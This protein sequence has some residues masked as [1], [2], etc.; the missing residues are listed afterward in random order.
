MS[1]SKPIIRQQKWCHSDQKYG[2]KDEKCMPQNLKKATS[3]TI[4][5]ACSLE[6]SGMLPLCHF[7]YPLDV[8]AKQWSLMC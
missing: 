5:D 7:Q 6:G 1:T 8:N 2:E 3:T 4:Q